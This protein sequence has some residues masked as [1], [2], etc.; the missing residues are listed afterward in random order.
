MRQRTGLGAI[1]VA[2]LVVT[3]AGAAGAGTRHHRAPGGGYQPKIRPADFGGP[4]DNPYFPLVPG[5]RWVYDVKTPEGPERIVVEV[6]H[7][8][9]EIVGISAV[10]VHDT[11]TKDGQLVED[12]LDYYGQDV[13]GNV[14]YFGEDT[15]AYKH[16]AISTNGS[17]EAGVDGGQPGIIMKAHPRVGAA[18][19]QE[20]L[21][22]Q[23]EDRARVLSVD[24]SASVPFDSFEHA[25]VKTKDITDLEPSL[26]EQK[27]YA[28]GVGVVL[29]VDVKGGSERVELVEHSTP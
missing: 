27:Y 21:K 16:G 14:W 7:D 1:A 13:A 12:T 6:T 15:K 28:P 25:V 10:V 4:V 2:L 23:A 20:F 22:G 11:A 29:E 5:A 8:T 26:V 24:A 18:Y 3:G 19:R 9:K 17:W